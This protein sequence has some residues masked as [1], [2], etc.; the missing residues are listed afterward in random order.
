M[1]FRPFRRHAERDKR[2]YEL[3][4]EYLLR[5]ESEGVTRKLVLEYLSPK[6]PPTNIE[7]IYQRILESAKNANM[8]DGVIR[9][10]IGQVERLGPILFDFRVTDVVKEYAADSARVLNKIERQFSPKKPFRRTSRSIWPQYCRTI[11]D[12]AQFLTQFSA[13]AEF[14]E[15]VDFFDKDDRSRP[16]LPLL[17]H[18]RI[19]GLGFTLACDFLKELGYVKFGKPD[20]QMREIFTGLGLCSKDANDHEL[21]EAIVRVAKNAGVSPY[22]ADKLFWLIGSGKFYDH[23]QI[24]TINTNKKRFIRE[25]K[26]KLRY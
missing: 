25:A 5:F 17:L 4:W 18:A 12:A 13:A 21:F 16:A 23:S 7:G 9:G 20:V 15:W 24:G 19:S 11:L 22:N 14:Y 3:A 6:P 1:T 2:A 10:A 26:G 8:K